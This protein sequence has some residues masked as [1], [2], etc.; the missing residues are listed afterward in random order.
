M[1][2]EHLS[3]PPG[4]DPS[5]RVE[6][7]LRG[8]RY[9]REGSPAVRYQD[10]PDGLLERWYLNGELDRVDGPAERFAPCGNNGGTI[11]VW[12]RN[13]RRYRALGS[14]QV[15]I[16]SPETACRTL[17]AWWWANRRGPP[18]HDGGDLWQVWLGLPRHAVAVVL[19]QLA[20]GKVV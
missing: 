17:F 6:A 5:R 2:V 3:W 16:Y 9:H 18:R 20:T 10:H 8:G 19:M 7:W 11:G 12:F 13:G 15:L 1:A 4:M 14:A